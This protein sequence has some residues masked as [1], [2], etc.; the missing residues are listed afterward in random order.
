M[1]IFYIREVLWKQT[2]IHYIYQ[3]YIQKCEGGM[4]YINGKKLF[5]KMLN[6]LYTFS[7]LTVYVTYYVLCILNDVSQIFAF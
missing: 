3:N 5:S 2:T 1:Y 6:F 4:V 7:S